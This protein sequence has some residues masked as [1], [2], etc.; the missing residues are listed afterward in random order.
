MSGIRLIACALQAI[1]MISLLMGCVN[2]DSGVEDLGINFAST[3]NL[4]KLNYKAS[5]GLISYE[6]EGQSFTAE[7][8]TCR[9][10][11][12]SESTFIVANESYHAPSLD[13][14]C[15]GWLAQTFMRENFAVLAVNLPG[16]G[17][18]TGQQDFGG[19]Q[20][21]EAI[22]AV[23]KDKQATSKVVSKISGIWG[24]QWG[25]VAAAFASKN[26]TL[27]HLV[28][29]NGIFDLERIQEGNFGKNLKQDIEKILDKEGENGVEVR[30]IAWD[31]EDLPKNIL[32]YHGKDN[33]EV[34]AA[35]AESFRD[36]LAT[37]EY[38]VNLRVLDQIGYEAKDSVHM[39]ILQVILRAAK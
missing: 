39:Q 35:D 24:Y 7:W 25:A 10:E 33:A 6:F 18:S 19:G 21:V 36:N 4:K 14:F 30:S 28:I 11:K 5:S 34:P 20:S 27:K 9:N 37:S 13:E 8:L 12:T 23:I 22:Q 1:F 29:G 38:K 26:L 17:R 32:M 15:S 3:P 2:G 16:Q 31:V